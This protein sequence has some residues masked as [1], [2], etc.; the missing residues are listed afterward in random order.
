[1]LVDRQDKGN[2]LFS[3][4]EIYLWEKLFNFKLHNGYFEFHMI[5]I[6]FKFIKISKL[7]GRRKEE[8][9]KN[10]ML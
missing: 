3:T 4:F 7:D 8:Y 5:K 9:L 10:R 1:M 6:I 2:A